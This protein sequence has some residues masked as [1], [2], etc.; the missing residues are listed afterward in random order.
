MK[1]QEKT[2]DR[3]LMNLAWNK[4]IE[5]LSRLTGHANN[6]VKSPPQNYLEILPLSKL[7]PQKQS[8]LPLE[9]KL[10]HPPLQ[11]T[12]LGKLGT[13]VFNRQAA[14]RLCIWYFLN[15]K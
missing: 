2:G 6:L 13:L 7:P 15:D 11:T 9:R 8:L 10:H 1:K 14:T 12:H 5:Q 3:K 4:E